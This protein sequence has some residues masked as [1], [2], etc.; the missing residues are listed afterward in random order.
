MTGGAPL[1]ASLRNIRR[2]QPELPS[3]TSMRASW[4]ENRTVLLR[5]HHAY[6]LEVA[7]Q[8]LKQLDAGTIHCH[9]R[10]DSR[11]DK[12]N[13]YTAV[14]QMKELFIQC[15]LRRRRRGVAGH[16]SLLCSVC[17]SVSGA[18]QVG[19]QLLFMVLWCDMYRAKRR[20]HF[21]QLWV[22]IARHSRGFA[23]GKNISTSMHQAHITFC[24]SALCLVLVAQ[25]LPYCCGP[26]FALPDDDFLCS[27]CL[28]HGHRIT[29]SACA[30][31][32]WA[33]N[34]PVHHPPNY[35]S[36]GTYCFVFLRSSLV[37]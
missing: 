35:S 13:A 37:S 27:F 36:H 11:R 25:C 26:H 16:L 14:T 30:D 31:A 23:V 15:T 3:I 33:V 8:C 29:A 7:S 24:L 6:A 9:D 12:A 28:Q 22:W 2:H 34:S 17:P 5:G 20:M 1:A 32:L 19:F 21:L 4:N 18:F 10:E